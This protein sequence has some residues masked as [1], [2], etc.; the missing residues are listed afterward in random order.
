M[1]KAFTSKLVKQPWKTEQEAFWAGDFGNQYVDRNQGANLVASNAHLFSQIFSRTGQLES[2][3]E[4]GSNIGL[5]L[6]AIHQIFPK[7]ELSGIEINKQAVKHLKQLKFLKKIYSS[8]IIDF[9]PDYPRDLAFIKAVLIHIHPDLL[10]KVYDLLYRSSKRFVLVA[11][12]YNTQP[13][14]IDYRGFAGKLFKRDF[15]GEMLDK[16]K[17]LKLV[18][19]GFV[20]HRDIAFPQDD[21][22]WFLME[23]RSR[24]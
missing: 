22:T 4:F 11:E 15:A 14:E 18:D 5:N 20:Y 6:E 24:D 16:F 13:V 17:N 3:L 1:G 12:Y 10:P 23:K 8:S 19:Y 21:L 7:V 9:I 2:V